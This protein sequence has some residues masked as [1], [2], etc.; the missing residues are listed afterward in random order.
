MIWE[1]VWLFG[2]SDCYVSYS[3]F[4]LSKSSFFRVLLPDPILLLC[5]QKW[6]DIC[7]MHLCSLGFIQDHISLRE[8]GHID[9]GVL[10]TLPPHYCYPKFKLKKL[11]AETRRLEFLVN[12]VDNRLFRLQRD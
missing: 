2:E 8:R 3:T 12:V 6:S 7:L 10:A 9:E 1:F 4:P 5:T 11:A